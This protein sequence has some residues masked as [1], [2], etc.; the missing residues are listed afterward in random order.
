MLTTVGLTSDGVY[1]SEDGGVN[2]VF[3]GKLPHPLNEINII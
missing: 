2:W 1:L 3:K